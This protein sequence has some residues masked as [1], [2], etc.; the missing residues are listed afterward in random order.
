M[1]CD[2]QRQGNI[3][4]QIFKF[5]RGGDGQS[6]ETAQEHPRREV[7]PPAETSSNMADARSAGASGGT[8]TSPAD[9]AVLQHVPVNF[10]QAIES[11][12]VSESTFHRAQ[13]RFVAV[14]RQLNTL[15]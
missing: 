5:F 3:V 8:M 10:H 11:D 7:L 15:Y 12:D 6:P 1:T 9:A 2:V 4:F 13:I 14:S